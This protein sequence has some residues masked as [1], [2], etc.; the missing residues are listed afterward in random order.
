MQHWLRYLKS[1]LKKLDDVP[2]ILIGNK[3]DLISTQQKV[4]TISYF[5]SL[6]KQYA[7][8]YV[9]L[10]A[11]KLANVKSV[12]TIF[13]QKCL[14]LL[15]SNYFVIPHLYKR[16]ADQIHVV[17]KKGKLFSGKNLFEDF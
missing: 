3:E 2:I 16:V 11:R 9:I 7:L 14:A 6:K 12:M 1:Q 10:S 8:D 17:R 5:D 4:D 13:Q 15:N